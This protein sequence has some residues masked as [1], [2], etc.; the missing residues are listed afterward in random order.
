M[1]PNK[2]QVKSAIRWF[3][4]MFGGAIIGWAT[5]RGWD[6]SG[7]LAAV[8]P[9]A[10]IGIV[11]SGVMLA[12]GLVSKTKTGLITAAVTTVPEVKKVEVAPISQT[13]ADQREAGRIVSATPPSV[14]ASG[15]L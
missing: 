9:E 13:P 7:V 11:A 14:V 4:S 2:E 5:S 3:V 10:L 12:W 15:R 8:N 6:V 1:E